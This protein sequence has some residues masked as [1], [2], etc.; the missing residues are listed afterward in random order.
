MNLRTEVE[1]HHDA[2]QRAALEAG[3][4]ARRCGKHTPHHPL[5]RMANAAVAAKHDRWFASLAAARD[6]FARS[7]GWICV[8]P[9]LKFF[10]L[11]QLRGIPIRRHPDSYHYLECGV[12]DH[13]EYFKLG[14]R[15]VAIL[16]HTWRPWDECLAL[17]EC[18]Q[19]HVERL[20]WSWYD[21]RNRIA[22]LF[23]ERQATS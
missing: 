19:L 7:R 15:P 22:A 12:I 14:L 20:D 6:E 1:T 4:F 11:G 5:V 2:W 9:S 23:T 17:A 21:P 3:E 16:S 8:K 10:T 18:E 13:A